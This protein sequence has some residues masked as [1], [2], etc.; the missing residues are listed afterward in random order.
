M[1]ACF[2]L[3]YKQHGSLP[4][5]DQDSAVIDEQYGDRNDVSQ[6][7]KHHAIGHRVRIRNAVTSTSQNGSVLIFLNDILGMFVHGRDG[8]ENGKHPD[9]G[10]LDGSRFNCQLSV[11]V[12][13][14]GVGA[15]ERHGHHTVNGRHDADER[16]R[17]D[18]TAQE[19]A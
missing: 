18:Y 15:V 7:E 8:E 12:E 19:I 1:L 17:V 10:E 11:S 9:T 4:E 2:L 14:N 3:S 13:Q 5:K 6:H 16:A